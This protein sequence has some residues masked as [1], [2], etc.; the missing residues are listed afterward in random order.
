MRIHQLKAFQ[1]EL[2]KFP[3]EV[4]EDILSLVHRY[5]KGE[6][7]NR[8]EFKTFKL[9]RN[10]KIQ[11]FKVKD[12][13]GNWRAVSTIVSKKALVFVCAFHKKS[14]ALLEKGKAVI[15]KRIGSI[16]L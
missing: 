4:R 5:L 16:E 1:K 15:K 3:L 8:T 9:D 12:S 6:R 7:L 13:K 11:E 2:A 10:T 14:Q